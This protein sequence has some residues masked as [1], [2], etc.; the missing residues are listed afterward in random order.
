M[1]S[2]RK[3]P[4]KYPSSDV[5]RLF[6]WAAGRCAYPGCAVECLREATAADD[7]K[8]IG[9]IAHIVAHGD[10]GPRADPTLPAEALDSYDNWILLCPTHHAVV[11]GQP[12]GHTVADL[13]KWKADHEH[14]VRERT[15]RAMPDV[16]F[17]ELEVVTAALV[18]GPS[19]EPTSNF[20][21]MNPAE[22]MAKNGLS[23][24][25]HWNLSLG[26]AKA[27]EVASF[28]EY[29]AARDPKFPERLAARFVEEYRRLRAEGLLGDA[30]FESLSQFSS[31]G[32]RDFP[33]MAAGLAVLA[34]LF[35]KCEVFES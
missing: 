23:E 31:G 10:T 26:L 15:A 24:A 4:R 35:E 6:G 14:W 20:K 27:N 1:A 8:V 9:E 12:N 19:R 22:K 30:L 3:G 34:Y 7:S 18:S 28:V 17:A 2:D 29:V 11:D 13:R 5:K 32:Q 21:V 16:T 33:R 25:V